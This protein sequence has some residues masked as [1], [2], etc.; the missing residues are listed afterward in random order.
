MNEL[1]TMDVKEQSSPANEEVSHKPQH[2]QNHTEEH[3]SDTPI[4]ESECGESCSGHEKDS[5]ESSQD[6]HPEH[7]AYLDSLMKE[8]E[9][10]AEPEMKL[11]RVIDFMEQALAQTG[12]PHFKSF[13]QARGLCLQLFKDNLAPAMRSTLWSKYTELSKEARRLKDLLDEQSA[14]AVEQIEIAIHALETEI[15]Q[16]EEA[17]ANDNRELVIDSQVLRSQLPF[18]SKVQFELDFL[19]KQASRI[20]ALRKELI[21]TEMRVR[22]K[23][24][25]FQRLSLLGDKVFPRRKE[26]ITELS[27]HFIADIDAFIAQYFTQDASLDSLF[28]LR[29]E[30]KALQGTAKILTLNTH[31]FTHT[32]M[33]LSECW[34]KIKHLEKERKK[35][36]AQQKTVFK[37]N[38][39]AA[40]QKIEESKTAIQAGELSPAEGNKKLDEVLSFMR[41]IE[42][43]RDELHYLREQIAIARQPLLEMMKSEEQKRIDQENERQRLKQQK[44]IDLKREIEALLK[45]VDN[46]DAAKLTVERDSILEKI[47]TTSL[48]KAEKLE[49]ERIL[50]PLRD[51]IADKKA[52]SLT[53]LSAD[54]RQA[55][56]QLKEMLQERRTLRQEIKEQVESLRK[57][58]GASGMDFVKGMEYNSQMQVQKE[59]LEKINQSIQDVEKKISELEKKSS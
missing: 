54:D 21:K 27:N 25:F 11:Q 42:L 45:T 19:N 31:A 44:V 48:V 37:E 26:L 33:R 57:A 39:D 18:Y 7:H 12:S 15:V 35:V 50:K 29:E 1:N 16:S 23:N 9:N 20:N 13:W 3:M 8:L 59:R 40:L 5:S 58:I 32:R 17:R 49:L 38:M 10:I 22:K 41:S 55:L 34:D 36:R 56:Q 51:I 2:E 28:F 47:Q 4:A 24:K 14:F 52:M 53:A 46:Y 6:E 30:I 43:G